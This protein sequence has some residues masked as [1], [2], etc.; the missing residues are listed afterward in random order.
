MPDD[1]LTDGPRWIGNP[2]WTGDWETEATAQRAR[3]DAAL[4]LARE[5]ILVA[6][7]FDNSH[8]FPPLAPALR[9]KLAELEKED[10]GD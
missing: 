8:H 2:P 6:E 9:A 3:A 1:R 10:P 5:A 7:D 4:A